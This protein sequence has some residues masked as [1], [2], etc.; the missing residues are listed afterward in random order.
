[1]KKIDQN[2]NKFKYH[3]GTSMILD[4]SKVQAGQKLIPFFP[5]TWNPSHNFNKTNRVNKVAPK[6]WRIYQQKLP[7]LPMTFLIKNAEIP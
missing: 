6:Y 5:R 4:N 1:M 7:K 3:K 2:F